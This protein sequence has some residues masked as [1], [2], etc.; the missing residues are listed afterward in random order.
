MEQDKSTLGKVKDL[1]IKKGVGTIVS[2]I[3]SYMFTINDINNNDISV[4]DYV[5]FRAEKVHNQNRAFFVKKY[6]ENDD[7]Y[8]KITKSKIYKSN[9]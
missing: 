2:S 4:D 6:N 7:L 1:D 3:D 5:K 9:K 8:G